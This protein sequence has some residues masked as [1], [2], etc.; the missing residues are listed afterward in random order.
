MKKIGNKTVWLLCLLA[1]PAYAQKTAFKPVFTNMTEVGVSFGQFRYNVNWAT[2]NVGKRQ[3]ITAQTFNGV[4]LRPKL[5]VGGTVGVDWY[6]AALIT[7]VCGGVRY[8]LAQPGKKNLRVFTSLDS[9]YGFTWLHEDPTG[10][11]TRGGWLITPGLGFRIG[12]PQNA[13]FIMSLSYR[14]QEAEAEKPLG[15]NEIYKHETRVYN[16]IAFR[17]GV[18]F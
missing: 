1:F 11:K 8:D 4:Q 3:N 2:E 5:A 13:N 16:R 12:R 9:G 15:W 6:T 14:R 17:L 10:Y 7:S 18:S